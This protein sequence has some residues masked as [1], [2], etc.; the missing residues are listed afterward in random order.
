MRRLF[1]IGVGAAVG[2]L[3]VRKISRTAEAY[4]PK[5]LADS[6]RGSAIGLL[7]SVRDFLEDARVA[8]A[9]H[10]VELTRALQEGTA[11]GGAHRAP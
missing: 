1:W 4:S 10:E 6:A 11:E 2:I 9:E 8:M 7:D 5:G 3:V